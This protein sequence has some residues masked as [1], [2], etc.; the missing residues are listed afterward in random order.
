MINMDKTMVMHNVE[1][2]AVELETFR[3]EQ[4][5]EW[6]EIAD[7]I[8]VSYSKIYELRKGNATDKTI[9]LVV[10]FLETNGYDNDKYKTCNICGERHP[11]TNEYFSK[12]Q[13]GRDGLTTY[14]KQ[15]GNERLYKY[16][17][18]NHDKKIEHQTKWRR[19]NLELHNLITGES[20]SKAKAKEAGVEYN[21]SVEEWIELKEDFNNTCGYCG[22]HQSRTNH[23]IGQDHIIPSKKGGPHDATNVIPSCI[24]CN[25]SKGQRDVFEWFR[26]QEFYTEKREQTIKDIMEEK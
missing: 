18:E 6:N 12:E 15:C 26:E 17:E 14:C 23:T 7:E 9:E 20:R 2:V 22:L 8:G 25:S 3:E 4:Y 5:L 24:H 11:R 16:Y 19:N 10:D 13:H 1:E 21:Y